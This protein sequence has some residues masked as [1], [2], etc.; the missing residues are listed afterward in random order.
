MT[1]KVSTSEESGAPGS[2]PPASSPSIS[3]VVAS[4][5]GEP[6]LAMCLES[7]RAEAELLSAEVIVVTRGALVDE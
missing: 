7:V 1:E 4:K 5:V 2:N 6:F 3:I